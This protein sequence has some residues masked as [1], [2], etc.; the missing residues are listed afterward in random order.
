MY[1]NQRDKFKRIVVPF[2]DGVK[3]LQVVTDLEKAYNK[4]CDIICLLKI[5]S[6]IIKKINIFIVFD[7]LQF[8]SYWWN[9]RYAE[10]LM[11]RFISRVQISYFI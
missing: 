5:N 11:N 6:T 4:V 9:L 8:Y 2:T 7:M 3:N 10:K 1:E